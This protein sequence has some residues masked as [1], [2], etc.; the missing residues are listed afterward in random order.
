MQSNY[1]H[2]KFLF[3]A[4]T[5]V[6]STV[7]L[8]GCLRNPSSDDPATQAPSAVNVAPGEVLETTKVKLGYIPFVES[9]PLV[10]AKEKGFFTN[11][12]LSEA[13]VRG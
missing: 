13:R 5:A 9:V 2:R 1:S 7:S 10:I 3:T 6:V 11:Y 8:K 12:G 4:A